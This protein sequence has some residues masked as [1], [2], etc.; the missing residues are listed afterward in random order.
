[1][2]FVV[3]A[4]RVERERP[5]P[6]AHFQDP[7]VPYPQGVEALRFMAQLIARPHEGRPLNLAIVGDPNFGKSHLLD[8]FADCYPDQQ[9]TDTEE[10]RIQVLL[11]SMPPKADGAALLRTLLTDMGGTF[12]VRAPLDEL[13][14]KFCIRA[15]SMQILLIMIDEFNNGHWGRLD[16]S[17]TLIHT[18]RA[19]SNSLRRPI[20]IAGTPAIGDILRHDRQ[21]DERF[22][23]I[24]LAKWSEQSE[25]AKLLATFEPCLGMAE[26]SNLSSDKLSG[27]VLSLAGPKLGRI[28]CLVRESRRLAVAEGHPSI[29][30]SH[31]KS[32]VAFLVGSKDS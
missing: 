27:L 9:G 24:A 1:M 12:N 2:T 32:A 31:L 25:V 28:A 30:E 8:H 19:I 10:P 21:L 23:K 20:V 26:P 6:R 18:L 11:S 29:T 5:S 3:K 4:V 15:Q 14:R 17:L 7:W 13:L 22:K 16:A